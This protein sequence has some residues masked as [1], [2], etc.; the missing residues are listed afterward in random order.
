MRGTLVV[1]VLLLAAA[2]AIVAKR[3]FRE[4]S[5]PPPGVAP[6]PSATPPAAKATP[7]PAATP[8]RP[9]SDPMLDRLEAL[10][11]TPAQLK[12][13]LDAGMAIQKGISPSKVLSPEQLATFPE[14]ERVL[15]ENVCPPKG[16]AETCARYRIDVP[17][18]T[19][20]AA[21]IIDWRHRERAK[22][23]RRLFTAAMGVSVTGREYPSY[24]N[25]IKFC[26][27]MAALDP[28]TPPPQALP[29]TAPGPS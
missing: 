9:P 7:P 28:A 15:V 12:A 5:V 6:A 22:V 8:L 17:R 21:E 20:R 10:P 29:Q 3:A 1:I 24:P 11:F 27:E 19:E 25:L 4:Q 23:D 2:A 26:R 14:I 18:C 13:L 16:S